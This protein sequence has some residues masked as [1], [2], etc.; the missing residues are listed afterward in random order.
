MFRAITR[1]LFGVIPLELYSPLPIAESLARLKNATDSSLFGPILGQAMTGTVSAERIRLTRT[2]GFFEND[3]KPVF[4]GRLEAHPS[5]SV[6]RGTF[7]SLMG[8]VFTLLCI[9]FGA[10]WTLATFVA[11]FIASA[12][13]EAS[14]LW[15][16]AELGL[17]M[18]LL[19]FGL[20]YLLQWLAWND[21]QYLTRAIARALT[22]D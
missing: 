15:V 8:K 5:G 17:K 13:P 18:V 6:L 1:P 4:V 14:F 7:V 3:F 19:G 9:S 2:I 12:S 21:R 20:A 22:P 11:I 10:F 16:F